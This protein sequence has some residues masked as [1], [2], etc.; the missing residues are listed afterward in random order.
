M[1]LCNKL[2][3]DIVAT[4][5]Q[6][7]GDAAQFKVPFIHVGVSNSYLGLIR[8]A[9]MNFE[10]DYC[11]QLAFD[12]INSPELDGYGVDQVKVAEG[13][14]CKA[15]CGYRPEDIGS[16][17]DTAREPMEQYSV[18]VVV[19]CILERATYIAMGNEIN[20]V[21]KWEPAL[22]LAT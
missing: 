16:A 2:C 21:R 20:V 6:M 4:V 19:E 17:F 12:N 11:M 14:G 10:M 1:N 7:P 9:Q 8:R 3:H 15:I 13:L 22:S 5:F 18:S